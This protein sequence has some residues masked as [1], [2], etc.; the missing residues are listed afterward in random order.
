MAAV[1]VYMG[2]EIGA[3]MFERQSELSDESTSGFTRVV[4]GYIFFESL[5]PFQQLFGTSIQKLN[6]LTY[7]S[8]ADRRFSLN[9]IQYPL[10]QLGIVGLLLWI[11]F[12]II[13][14]LKVPSYAKLCVLT[15]FVL[16][17]IEVTYL[18]SYMMLLTIIPVAC[19]FYKTKSK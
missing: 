15:F 11:L 16:S 17:S 4:H 3:A 5:D 13:V 19:Y 7:L 12:Y 8:Y 18:G 2:T 6:D 10:I 14:L 9:G 1:Y